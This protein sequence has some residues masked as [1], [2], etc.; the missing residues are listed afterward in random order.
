MRKKIRKKIDKLP[1]GYYNTSNRAVTNG[2][3][4]GKNR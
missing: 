4:G 2:G 1:F 3:Y